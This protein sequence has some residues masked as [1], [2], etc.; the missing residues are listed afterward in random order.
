LKTLI[1]LHWAKIVKRADKDDL[2]QLGEIQAFIK[3]KTSHLNQFLLLKGK[4]QLV[5]KTLELKSVSKKES[6]KKNGHHQDE[7]M[8]YKDASD[9]DEEPLND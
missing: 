6:K 5:E 3:K 4:L 7:V 1:S 2:K 8:V 9:D